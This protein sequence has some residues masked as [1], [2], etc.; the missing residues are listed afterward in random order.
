MILAGNILNII[1]PVVQILAFALKS[2]RRV[3]FGVVIASVIWVVAYLLL[4][5]TSATV[6]SGIGVITPIINYYLEK[7]NFEKP[8]WMYMM[9]ILVIVVMSIVF[10]VNVIELIPS[11]AV[12]FLV[13]S[14]IPHKQLPFRMSLILMSVS[15]LVYGILK[16]QFGIIAGNAIQI[17]FLLVTLFF[18]SFKKE[19]KSEDTDA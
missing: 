18:Y 15:W 17:V 11:F 8:W 3:L 9:F 12:L 14:T 6:L 13:L 19:K 5:A 1:A 2:K 10:Y 4:G 16:M 7:N